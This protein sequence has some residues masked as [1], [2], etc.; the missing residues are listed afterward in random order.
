MKRLLIV[1]CLV[2]WS[3][4][5]AHAQPPANEIILYDFEGAADLK[6]WSNLVLPATRDKEPPVNIALSTEHATAGKHSLKL[7]FNGGN[8]P[9]ISTTRVTDDWL[10]YA[11][12][13]RMPTSRRRNRGAVS[14]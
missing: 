1:S 10:A 6:T 11:R 2:S 12:A 9:T 3:H 4:A 8:W 7:T 13:G 14:S 5:G